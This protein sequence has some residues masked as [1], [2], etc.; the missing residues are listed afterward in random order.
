M[1]EQLPKDSRVWW[2]INITGYGGFAYFGTEA[3]ANQMRKDK[4]EWEG[5]R[6]TKRRATEEEAAAKRES[7]RCQQ[8]R[9]CNLDER[10]LE[11]IR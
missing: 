7:V 6:G 4:A 1:S 10:E 8:S 9:G 5:G 3:E 11:S 2:W